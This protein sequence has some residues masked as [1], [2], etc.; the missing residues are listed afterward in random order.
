MLSVLEQH[1]LDV[2]SKNVG[3]PWEDSPGSPVY[4]AA[5]GRYLDYLLAC[6]D[7]VEMRSPVVSNGTIK[8][9][10]RGKSQTFA[11]AK[12]RLQ[13]LVLACEWVREQVLAVKGAK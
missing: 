5:C 12:S 6:A 11:G 8:V 9:T 13:L 4:D 7:G 2:V 10:V 1:A 3:T